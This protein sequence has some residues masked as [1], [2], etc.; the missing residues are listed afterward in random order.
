MESL[1]TS[2]NLTTFM[3]SEVI[4]KKKIYVALKIVITRINIYDYLNFHFASRAKVTQLT[5]LYL[6]HFGS[7]AIL[8][9]FGACV[10]ILAKT[11]Q[12]QDFIIFFNKLFRRQIFI[13]FGRN[14]DQIKDLFLN[15]MNMQ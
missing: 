4:E 1:A 15:F 3:K 8:D 6:R 7:R 14:K 12:K 2:T 11:K 10:K 5:F 9:R 13:V